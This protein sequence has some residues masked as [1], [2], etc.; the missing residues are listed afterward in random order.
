[1]RR[2]RFSNRARPCDAPILEAAQR[3]AAQRSA[4][5]RSAAHCTPARPFT[6]AHRR[7]MRKAAR[8]VLRDF[9][10]G[11]GDCADAALARRGLCASLCERLGALC[12]AELGGSL[13][14]SAGAQLRA[15]ALRLHSLREGRWKHSKRHSDNSTARAALCAV[16]HGCAAPLC[17]TS[18]AWHSV[19]VASQSS[20]R[21]CLLYTP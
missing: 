5:Q 12:D 2:C 11:T 4:A 14:E 1:M 9:R 21:G 18:A 20:L 6:R 13:A 8:L 3:S 19:S 17:H 7:P 10:R 15:A 16:P